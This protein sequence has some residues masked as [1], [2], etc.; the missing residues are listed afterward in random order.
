LLFFSAIFALSAVSEPFPKIGSATFVTEYSGGTVPF[1]PVKYSE[2]TDF[3]R[4]HRKNLRNPCNLRLL[5]N[6]SWDFL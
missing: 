4:L 3:H 1:T 6:W 2:T 5:L